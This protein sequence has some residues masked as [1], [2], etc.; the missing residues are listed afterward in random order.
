MFTFEVALCSVR[1][2]YQSGNC[3]QKWMP[4]EV[5]VQRPCSICDLQQRFC[6]VTQRSH[7][8]ARLSGLLDVLLGGI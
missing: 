7:S 5:C 1:A 8:L 3:L 4:R 6:N 2:P